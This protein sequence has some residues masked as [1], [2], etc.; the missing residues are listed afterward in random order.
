MRAPVDRYRTLYEVAKQLVLAQDAD[1]AAEIVFRSLLEIAGA[2]RGFIIVREGGSFQQKV[3][4]GFDRAHVSA[5]D[6]R[7]SRTLVREVIEQRAPLCWDESTRPDSRR[8]PQTKSLFQIGASATLVVPL[9]ERRPGGEPG[10]VVAVLYLDRARGRG[11]FAEHVPG[12]VTE[13]AEVA[14]T[15]IRRA[16]DRQ[17]LSD[18][19]RT[20]EKDLLAQHDFEGIVTRDPA[21]LAL[22]RT[23]AQVADS[24]ASALVRGETGTGKEL[25]ARA[26]HVNSP[27]RHKPLVTLHCTALPATVLE[28]ELFGHVRGAFTGADRDRVGRAAS[29]HGGTLFLDE[30]AEIPPEAQAKLLRFLQFGEIQRLGSDKVEKVDVRVVSATHRDLE[31]MVAQGRFRQDLYYRLKVVEVELPPLRARRGD[32]PLLVDAFLKRFS[33]GR[34]TAPPRFSAEAMRAIEAHPFPG[35]VRELSHLVERSVVLAR[36]PEIELADLPREVVQNGSQN[37]SQSG[38]Q[39]GSLRPPSEA[40]SPAVPA[41]RPSAEVAALTGESLERAREE[42]ISSIERDFL[43]RL[44]EKAGGNVSRAARDAGMHRSYLQKLLAKHE[45]APGASPRDPQG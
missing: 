42:A 35:N 5:E 22:L 27:R 37:G 15:F 31:E 32:I 41:R 30:V 9:V 2:D 11:G 25:I 43:S 40:Q 8:F 20:L 36:G 21:M 34:K 24:S 6:R 10:D 4:L 38:S 33:H 44:L 17:A 14:A 19:A 23:V 39:S 28:S 1:A 29:A 45:G 26:L 18:R 13:I 7:F 3:D 12:I 16:L